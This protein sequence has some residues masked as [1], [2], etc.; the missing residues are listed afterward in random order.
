MAT[1][2][3]LAGICFKSGSCI[4]AS[5]A[6]RRDLRSPVSMVAGSLTGMMGP[7]LPQRE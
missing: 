4:C 1:L 6:P 7:M 5:W 2:S 3:E